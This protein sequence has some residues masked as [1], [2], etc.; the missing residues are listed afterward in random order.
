LSEVPD[1]E[2][3]LQNTD[4]R[5][6]TT[7]M[8]FISGD[9]QICSVIMRSE[10]G[11]LN[12]DDI[13][14]PDPAAKVASL[15]NHLELTV[16]IVELAAAWHKHDLPGVQR[17]CSM[18]FNRLIWGNLKTLPGDFDRLPDMLLVP[19]QS[20]E[21]ADSQAVVTLAR[22]GEPPVSVRLLKENSAW[23]IDEISVRQ[24]D[25]VVFNI[26][27]NL[28]RDIAQRFLDN[29][30]GGIM[31]AVNETSSDGP[32]GVVH[33]LGETQAPRRGNLTLPSNGPPKAPTV[34]TSRT[35]M[36]PPGIDMTPAPKPNSPPIDGIQRFGPAAS[37]AALAD[38]LLHSEGEVEEIVDEDV[39]YFNGDPDTKPVE[40]TKSVEPSRSPLRDISQHPIEIPGE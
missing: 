20:T 9:G 34:G 18:D 5:G 4:V 30:D 27:Q 16:P 23:L 25:G 38:T 35:A 6:D 24:P 29:P 28:R 7:E 1:G 10:N 21:R 17:T 14:Y 26:R 13:Q 15:R 22:A 12:V 40:P 2:L 8:E 32:P 37:A 33:A 19:V 3:T 36:T 31:Q 11:T 39:V